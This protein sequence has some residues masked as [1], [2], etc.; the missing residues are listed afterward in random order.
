MGEGEEVAQIG[1]C[2]WFNVLKGYGF[3]TPDE[4]GNDVFVHQSELNMDGFR[5]L[6][7]GERV[8]FVIRKKPEGNEAT[9]VKSAEPGG[10]LKGSSIRP[11]GKNKS[12]V[13]RCFKC[14]HYGNHTAAKCKTSVGVEKACYGCLAADHLVADCPQKVYFKNDNKTK[15]NGT[16]ESDA[17][18]EVVKAESTKEQQLKTK[19]EKADS[20]MKEITVDKDNVVKSNN[21]F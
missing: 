9:A 1:T 18:E 10:K 3:I 14:G 15:N 21:C 12:H 8:R 4:G 16:E 20:K 2:K 17:N 5:S 7:A 11:L 13:I 6:D 19:K